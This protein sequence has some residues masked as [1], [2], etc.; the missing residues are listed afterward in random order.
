MSYRL[1]VHIGG[2]HDFEAEGDKESVERQ[3]AVFTELVRNA[4]AKSSSH[5]GELPESLI[6][7][8]RTDTESIFLATLPQGEN[9][10][11]DAI[12]LI[13]LAYLLMRETKIVSGSDLLRGL[14]KSGVRA[15]RIDRAL[16]N[17][18]GGTHALVVKM[19]IR[20][21]V[22]YKLTER[23]IAKAKELAKNF[24]GH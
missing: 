3:F 8:V 24:A 5:K 11:A 9:P 6:Q 21:G 2:Q 1:K 19:G 23:G 16:G 18:I 10:V 15:E 4:M 13:L 14:K 20:R 22:T 17:Y 7:F 12:L